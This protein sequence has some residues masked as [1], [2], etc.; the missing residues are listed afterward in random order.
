[1][2]AAH[3]YSWS[4]VQ[5]LAVKSQQGKLRWH[6]IILSFKSCNPHPQGKKINKYWPLQSKISLAHWELSQPSW[7][8]TPVFCRVK[9]STV[10]FIIHLYVNINV[11]C[12]TVS[13]C[14][15][16]CGQES[17]FGYDTGALCS[18]SMIIIIVIFRIIDLYRFY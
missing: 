16:C 1:M 7:L 18:S 13:G 15:C 12:H 6:Q 8:P 10:Y 9:Y 4:F 11:T 2:G 3:R 5:D 17:L 14:A